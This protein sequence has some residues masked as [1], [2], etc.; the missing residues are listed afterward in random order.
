MQLI[1]FSL[2]KPVSLYKWVH[3]SFMVISLYMFSTFVLLQLSWGIHCK[4]NAL[5]FSPH[6]QSSFI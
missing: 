4:L 6:V 2:T 3:I 1:N 5:L